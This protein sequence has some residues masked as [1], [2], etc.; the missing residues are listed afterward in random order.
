MGGHDLL[1]GQRLSD[2]YGIVRQLAHGGMG[3]IYEAVH[4]RLGGKRY[5]I[6]VLTSRHASDPDSVARFRR[7]ARVTAGLCNEHIVEVHDFNVDG[8]LAYLVMELLVGEDLA[9]RL[10]RAKPFSTDATTRILA[11]VVTALDAAHRARI[12]H[13]D[14]KPQNI[15]LCARDGRDDYVKVLD[16]GISKLLDS[17]TMLT[18]ENALLGTPYYMAPEQALGKS[19]DIDGR[20]DVF[21][22]GAILWEL[23]TGRVAFGAPTLSAALYKVCQVDPPDVHMVRPDLP[24]AVSMVLRRALA[25]DL[26]GRTPDVV[27]LGREF[28]AALQGV[29]PDSVPP[30]APG[31]MTTLAEVL[32]HAAPD[33]VASSPAAPAPRLALPTSLEGGAG[34]RPASGSPSHGAGALSAA[35]NMVFPAQ[36]AS[37]ALPAWMPSWPA[38]YGTAHLD[39]AVATPMATGSVH[40]PARRSRRR[41]IIALAAVCVTAV[42]AVTGAVL[43]VLGRSSN[44]TGASAGQVTAVAP[45]PQPPPAPASQP[46]DEVAIFFEVEPAGAEVALRVD[47]V[48]V[49][50]RHMRRSG[51][52]TPLVVTAAAAG[53]MPFRAEFIPDRD[54]VVKVSLRPSPA[55]AASSAPPRRAPA[56]ASTTRTEPHPRP[57]RA[58]TS[59]GAGSSA[60]SPEPASPAREPPSGTA[61]PASRTHY[62]P[63]PS[64][65]GQVPPDAGV[66]SSPERGAS[67]P[68]DAGA[69]KGPDVAPAA[70]PQPGARPSP[71]AP[72]PATPPPATTP[73]KPPPKTGTIFDNP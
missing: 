43:G 31:G 49:T 26:A 34:A 72:A 8:E 60:P 69:P 47:G 30:P 68:P 51:A 70:P 53:Y 27:T 35:A 6:K 44:D 73:A 13:R 46:S 12:V 55:V 19:Q 56:R 15:F 23:L 38:T 29:A 52:R 42:G 41:A 59:A 22:L 24:P 5:A 11:Q 14:L 37:A 61:P 64:V 40:V 45:P 17:S 57:P 9:A 62:V 67:A 65:T 21:A 71:Q 18:G 1:V 63:S 32:G 10:K 16:F 33:T 7:E 58:S 20:A 54:Q 66:A 3:A 2:T 50:D 28:A 25:K 36:A 4:L 39:P 48:L